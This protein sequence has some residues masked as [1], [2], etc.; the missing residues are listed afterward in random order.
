MDA[1]LEDTTA[2]RRRITQQAMLQSPDTSQDCATDCIVSQS[3]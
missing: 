2:Y 3:R 1:Q